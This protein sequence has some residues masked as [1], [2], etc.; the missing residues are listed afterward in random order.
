MDPISETGLSKVT[1]MSLLH[2][3]GVA[4]ITNNNVF[5]INIQSHAQ[6]P[7]ASSQTSKPSSPLDYHS[8]IFIGN[9]QLDPLVLS[10]R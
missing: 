9:L 8:R 7:P 5:V 6:I 10:N 4:T 1:G 3:D 2:Y